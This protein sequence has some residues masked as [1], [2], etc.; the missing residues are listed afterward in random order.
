MNSGNTTRHVVGCMTGTSLDGIDLAL[1]EIRGHGLGAGARLMRT[2]TASFDGLSGLGEELRRA[3]EQSPLSARAFADLSLRLGVFHV[4]HIER[5]LD[6]VPV[7]LVCAHGQTV[8]HHPPASWQLLNPAPIAHRLRAPVVFDLRAADLAA[9]GQGAPIT[10]IADLLMFGNRDETRAIVNLGGF[11]NITVLPPGDRSA[12]LDAVEGFDLCACNHVLDRVAR[13]VLGTSYDD[14]GQ[15]ALAGTSESPAVDDL[16]SRLRAQRIAGRSLGTGDEVGPWIAAHR[17]RV[18][19]N[20]LASSACGAL[21]RVIGGACDGTVG[22]GARVILAG[23]GV[24]NAAL[25][26]AIRSSFGG[27]VELSESL[28]VPAAYREAMAMAVL[29]ALCQDRVPITLPRVTGCRRPA[30]VAGVWVLP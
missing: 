25:V 9:G 14:G 12:V 11:C 15:A 3:A 20:D 18:K 19:P 2:R 13:D 26:A 1:V 30:P 8:F 21:G 16:A 28:G 4:E 10:P 29:G 23:G 22:G 6:G 27:S 17:D 7:D 24:R 5:L